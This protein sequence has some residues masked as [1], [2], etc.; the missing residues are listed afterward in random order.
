M[1][2][3]DKFDQCIKAI[4]DSKLIIVDRAFSNLLRTL[5]ITPEYLHVVREAASTTSFSS[6]MQKCT[7]T[8]EFVLPKSN[9][10]AVALTVGLLLEFDKRKISV[11]DFV[12]KYFPDSTS[13]GCFQKFI[14]TVIKPFARAFRSLLNGEN[15][16]AVTEGAPE[17]RDES[18]P[19]NVKE[20]IAFWLK[21]L[22]QQVFLSDGADEGVR[23]DA[24]DALKGMM[25][26][27]EFDN[28]LLIKVV[29]IAVRYTLGALNMGFRELNSIFEI[30][31][32]Y[33]I[34]D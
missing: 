28:P 19:D 24:S 7:E 26:A 20:E 1:Q 23:S 25:Y 12:T 30:L 14:E 9:K 33:G 18:L 27:L 22:M 4:C 2:I 21:S 32:N 5:V 15:A 31:R 3:T 13:N 10:S 8:G 17:V 11:T 29:W 6:E 34:T 16:I